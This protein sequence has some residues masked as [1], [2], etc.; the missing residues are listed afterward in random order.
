ML[1]YKEEL[2]VSLD[3]PTTL[4]GLLRR[5]G[6][7]EGS[8]NSEGSHATSDSGHY[9]HDETEM[10]N[11]SGLSSDRPSLTV[12]D[13]RDSAEAEGPDGGELGWSEVY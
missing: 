2:S 4:Q 7:I 12:E 13:G 8:S 6:D 5:P 11:L 1:T 10:T 3:Q 9:S